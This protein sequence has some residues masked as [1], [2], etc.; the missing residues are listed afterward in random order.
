MSSEETSGST[1]PPQPSGGFKY[2]SFVLFAVA[3]GWFTW[4][5]V[6]TLPASVQAQNVG[7]APFIL[8]QQSQGF[9]VQGPTIQG[10][11]SPRVDVKV[12]DRVLA[13]DGT[14]LDSA[15]SEMDVQKLQTAPLNQLVEWEVQTGDQAARKISFEY[16][17]SAVSEQ[18]KAFGVSNAEQIAIGIFLGTRG[19]KTLLFTGAA[20]VIFAARRKSLPNLALVTG[21]AAYGLGLG[22]S[23]GLSGEYSDQVMPLLYLSQFFVFAGGGYGILAYPNGRLITVWAKLFALL[24]FGVAVFLFGPEVAPILGMEGAFEGFAL[25]YLTSRK[26][27]LVFWLGAFANLLIRYGRY[28]TAIERMEIRWVLWAF[29]FCVITNSCTIFGLIPNPIGQE[30]LTGLFFRLFLRLP[31]LRLS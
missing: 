21:F 8:Q 31:R 12:G 20:I 30:L 3:L 11:D 25:P 14:T 19:L 4:V 15:L 22:P 26:I 16:P 5:F 28:A 10:W 2:V 18:L 1:P 24:W 23:V 17:H 13:I 9:V 27:Q 29:A 6:S 7:V